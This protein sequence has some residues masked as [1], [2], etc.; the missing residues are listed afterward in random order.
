MRRPRPKFSL[1]PGTDRFPATGFR[2]AREGPASITELLKI[3]LERDP[4]CARQL[5]PAFLAAVERQYYPSLTE[6]RTVNKHACPAF[7]SQVSGVDP[8]PGHQVAPFTGLI[9]PRPWVT[10]ACPGLNG[11]DMRPGRGIEGNGSVPIVGFEGVLT[12]LLGVRVL[13]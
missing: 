9:V 7:L 13:V 12:D 2:W 1:R 8:A 6:A 3:N 10:P 4:R 5:A 11:H